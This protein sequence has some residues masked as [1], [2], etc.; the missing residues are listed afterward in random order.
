MELSGRRIYLAGSA[1]P[2]TDPARLRYGHCLVDQLVRALA[3][4]G[5]TFAVGVG[6][7]PRLGDQIDGPA[8]LFDWT[9]MEAAEANK[10]VQRAAAAGFGGRLIQTI[11]TSKTDRQIPE[12]R[13]PLWSRLLTAD[14]VEILSAPEGWYS[15]IFRRQELAQHCDLAIL[16]SGGAGVEQIAGEFAAQGKSVI[17]LDLDLG[18]SSNDGNGGAVR[19][20][21][22]MRAQ[23]EQFFNLRDPAAAGALLA[24]MATHN[25]ATPV[26][27]VVQALLEL[28]HGLIPPS[29]FYVRLLNPGI[30]YFAEVDRFFEQ[31]VS[32][33]VKQ[34]GYEP[35]IMGTS[36]NTHTWM[37]E[38][39]F[40]HLLKSRLVVVDLTAVR[41][42]CFLELG[43]ALR[44][45]VPVLVTS[46]RGTP[47]QFDTH[48]LDAYVWDDTTDDTVRQREFLAYWQRNEHRPLLA[49]PKR[50]G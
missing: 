9:V 24:R 22:A 33:A 27:Q 14:A 10:E 31:V 20:A 37:N 36:P 42:N 50:W 23:P 18:S 32:P 25:G 49:K 39:I 5:A 6:K 48:A 40:A 30:E 2:T 47:T 26:E 44:G 34:R 46:R 12:W 19:L 1:N 13:R 8:L 7:E 29:V 43:F 45:T 28:L 11:T 3:A 38:Q 4:E 17:P 15:G 21:S 35:A 41:P 16:L